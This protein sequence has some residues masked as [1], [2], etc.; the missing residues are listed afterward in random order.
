MITLVELVQHLCVLFSRC[1]KYYLKGFVVHHKIVCPGKCL[2]TLVAFVGDFSPRV[3]FLHL[4]GITR[5]V[6]ECCHKGFLIG[7][8]CWTFL[9]VSPSVVT[10]V[11]SGENGSALMDPLRH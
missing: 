5:C 1:V 3:V 2:L 7:C 10:K 9:V 11:F 6:F 4:L 8:I